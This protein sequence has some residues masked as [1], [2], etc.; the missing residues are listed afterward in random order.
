V[1]ALSDRLGRRKPLLLVLSALFTLC[2]IPW[3]AGT[4]MPLALSLSLFTLMGLCA[5]GFTLTWA[6]A[7]EVN[8]HELSGMATSLVNTGIFLGTAIYQ[9]LIGW[10][11]DRASVGRGA[12]VLADYR[13]ALALLFVVSA[14]GVFAG[15]YLRE[16]PV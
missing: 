6:L 11:L 16:E 7:K 9:P 13:Y 1:G 10:M 15:T 3:I 12:Y 14:A 2:W 5:A 8:P 4:A